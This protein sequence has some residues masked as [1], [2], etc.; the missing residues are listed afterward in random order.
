[1][2]TLFAIAMIAMSAS[3]IAGTPSSEESECIKIAT[4]AKS[5]STMKASGISES[6]LEA[7]ISQPTIQTYPITLIRHRIYSEQATS[8]ESQYRSWYNICLTVGSKNLAQ[9]LHDADDLVR[10]RE[11]N[12]R[13]KSD[14]A[15]ARE[16][17][18]RLNYIITHPVINEPEKPVPEYG[19]PIGK[20]ILN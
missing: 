17:N 9:S 3:V 7:Y 2:K 16:N 10:L 19:S 5:I 6:D 18:V 13:L 4:F 20:K 8:P 14:L 15:L 11:E 1:M 12:N